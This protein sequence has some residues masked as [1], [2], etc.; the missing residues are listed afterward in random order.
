[1]YSVSAH[2]KVDSNCYVTYF[3][4]KPPNI[5]PH[6]VVTVYNASY[7]NRIKSQW[8]SN[9]NSTEYGSGLKCGIDRT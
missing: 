8:Q 5:C 1:V 2:D 3:A 6:S 9:G 7:H 4:D